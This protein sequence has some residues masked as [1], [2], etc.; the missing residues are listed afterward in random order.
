MKKSQ[1]KSKLT[2][3]RHVSSVIPR[4]N[5]SQKTIINLLDLPFNNNSTT[6]EQLKEHFNFQYSYDKHPP[7]E[8]EPNPL[9]FDI[10]F[11]G[12]LINI[13]PTDNTF[14]EGNTTSPRTEM[15]HN[16]LLALETEYTISFDQKILLYPSDTEYDFAFLQIFGELNPNILVRYRNGNYELVCI[17]SGLPNKKIPQQ[18]TNDLNIWRNWQITFKLSQTN[19]YVR[20]YRNAFLQAEISNVPTTKENT[21]YFKHGIYGQ[22]MSPVSQMSIITRNMKI[23][24]NRI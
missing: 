12:L 5:N 24:N 10:T 4:P 7:E 2:I 3:G 6:I 9:Y 14:Q 19:G 1:L 13:Y 8:S 22:N 20:I 15:K 21:G 11:D 23:Q 17:S 16:L 18:V